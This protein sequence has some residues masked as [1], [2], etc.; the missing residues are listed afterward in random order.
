M[1]HMIQDLD[2][3]VQEDQGWMDHA[4]IAIQWTTFVLENA[5]ISASSASHTNNDNNI[6]RNSSLRQSTR[7]RTRTGDMNRENGMEGMM[8]P[9]LERNTRSEGMLPSLVA[10]RSSTLGILSSPSEPGMRTG[11][12]RQLLESLDVDPSQPDLPTTSFHSTSVDNTDTSRPSS[13]SSSTLSSASLSPNKDDSPSSSDAVAVKESQEMVYRNAIMAALRH[14]KTIDIA[15]PLSSVF[16]SSSKTGTR[17]GSNRKSTSHGHGSEQEQ[18][19]GGQDTVK[20]GRRRTKTR[21]APDR[22]LKEWLDNSSMMSLVSSVIAEELLHEDGDEEGE[23][24]N[25]FSISHVQA[26]VEDKDINR[27]RNT[28][29]ELDVQANTPELRSPSSSSSSQMR[30]RRHLLV[31]SLSPLQKSTD[32]TSAAAHTFTQT[33]LLPISTNTSTETLSHALN[34]TAATISG[35][36]QSLN[37]TLSPTL[38]DE[39]VF[40]KQHILHLDKLRAQELN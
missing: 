4:E 27:D 30:R 29:N 19:E 20:Q 8:M 28:S 11:A 37:S 38:I 17:N 40:L 24:E 2:A 32:A 1:I 9:G 16:F 3:I 25:D 6:N 36:S 35:S 13:T 39:R 23:R 7:I 18:E 14:L 31:G 15:P 26:T 10:E 12:K 21:G 22:T 5:L 33:N 34:S